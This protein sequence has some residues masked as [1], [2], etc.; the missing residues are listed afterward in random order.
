MIRSAELKSP[1][2]EILLIAFFSDEKF[3]IDAISKL[4]VQE[5]VVRRQGGRTSGVQNLI[6]DFNKM[7]FPTLRAALVEMQ[8]ARVLPPSYNVE[9]A[10][11]DLVMCLPMGDGSGNATVLDKWIKAPATDLAKN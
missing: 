11:A 1:A 2:D 4:I 9:L 6:I 3:S 7:P 5:Y 10:D 8:S